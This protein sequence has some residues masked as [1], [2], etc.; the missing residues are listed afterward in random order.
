VLEPEAFIGEVVGNLREAAY[1]AEFDGT[2]IQMKNS[3]DFSESYDI[4]LSNGHVWR[5]VGSYRSTCAPAAFPINPHDYIDKIRVGFFGFK[6]PDGVTPPRNGVGE[7]PVGCEGFVTA[8]PKDKDNKDVPSNVHGPEI[9]WDLVASKTVVRM[10]HVEGQ[11][12]NQELFGVGPGD[13]RLC[14]TVL[15]VEGCLNGRV[16]NPE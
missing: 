12:F 8:T 6:C 10:E 5:G 7:L 1:C 13:F 4:L 15:G 2:V 14:A 11:P 3:N 16:I 9:H